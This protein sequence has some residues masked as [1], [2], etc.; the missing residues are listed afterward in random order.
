M[1][2]LLSQNA[3]SDE[4]VIL[5]RCTICS[6]GLEAVNGWGSHCEGGA[7]D[8]K[9]V[10]LTKLPHKGNLDFEYRSTTFVIQFNSIF[11]QYCAICIKYNIMYE[12]QYNV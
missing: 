5:S 11:A 1:L 4:K 6:V 3:Q 10:S 9:K 8:D 7:T 2:V 12:L